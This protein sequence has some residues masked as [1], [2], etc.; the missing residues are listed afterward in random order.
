MHYYVVISRTRPPPASSHRYS[1]TARSSGRSGYQLSPKEC[2]A[3]YRLVEIAHNGGD[4]IHHL[5][6]PN[7]LLVRLSNKVLAGLDWVPLTAGNN[8]D[9]AFVRDKF[10]DSVTAKDEEAVLVVKDTFKNLGDG[11]NANAFRNLITKRSSHCETRHH[12]I[13]QP[14]TSRSNGL[15]C[16]VNERLH[17]TTSLENSSLLIRPLRFLIIGDGHRLQLTR[18][19]FSCNHCS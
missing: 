9:S 10:P 2:C 13:R 5:F 4:I 16:L 1:Q 17:A 15:A 3:R 6:L 14:D 12:K 11:M 18:S 7:P 8:G 19:F